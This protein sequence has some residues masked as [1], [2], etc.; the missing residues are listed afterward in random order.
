M[1]ILVNYRMYRARSFKG[2]DRIIQ[3]VC[4]ALYQQKSGGGE[5]NSPWKAM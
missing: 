3:T 5:I 4:A 2:N 1:V